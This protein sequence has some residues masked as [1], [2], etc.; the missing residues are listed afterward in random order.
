MTYRT[1]FALDGVWYSNALRFD[2]VEPAVAE[3]RGR[4]ARW[5]L[6]VAWRVV[7]DDVPEK[8]PYTGAADPTA[9]AVSG[10]ASTGSAPPTS[11]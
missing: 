9:F 6:P 7:T 1:E 4:F 8:Q 5:L 11:C 2:E 10:A 3:A